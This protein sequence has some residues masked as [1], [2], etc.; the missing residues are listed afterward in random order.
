[1]CFFC[2]LTTPNQNPIRSNSNSLNKPNCCLNK[3]NLLTKTKQFLNSIFQVPSHVGLHLSS[4]TLTPAMIGLTPH[5]KHKK[6]SSFRN[7]KHLLPFL[8]KSGMAF[9]G[10]TSWICCL[11]LLFIFLQS[12]KSYYHAGHFDLLL[13][14]SG[15]VQTEL[16]SLSYVVGSRRGQST[17]FCSCLS[18]TLFS[19]EA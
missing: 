14:S 10:H 19:R 16:I 17:R 13:I 15:S 11:I 8:C 3:P 6:F 18:N 12:C 9:Q 2:K 1:M 7:Y 5:K 4:G